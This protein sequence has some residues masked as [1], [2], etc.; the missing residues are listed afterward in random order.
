MA[1]TQVAKQCS[2][3]PILGIPCRSGRIKLLCHK[4]RCS[5]E[6]TALPTSNTRPNFF[7][8][9]AL[10]G[11]RTIVILGVIFIGCTVEGLVTNYL[12]S[13]KG[14]EQ[15]NI[16][17]QQDF[18]QLE[19]LHG[20]GRKVQQCQ[21]GRPLAAAWHTHCVSHSKAWM[22]QS[23]VLEKDLLY[24]SDCLL[25]FKSGQDQPSVRHTTR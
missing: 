15:S 21:E 8:H 2:K 12:P 18:P 23:G 7:A 11:N 20:D 22:S 1:P 5:K 24:N 3:L 16:E 9:I 25:P 13:T 4:I 17:F 10:R 14:T 19:P 6:S